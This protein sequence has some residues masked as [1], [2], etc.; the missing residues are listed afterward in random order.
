M[1]FARIYLLANIALALRPLFLPTTDQITDIPLTPTQRS[2][3]G[4]DP[5][6]S[7]ATPQ[8]GGYITPPRYRRSSGSFSG[9]NLGTP[10]SDRRSISATYYSSSP[11]SASQ[12]FSPGAALSPFRSPSRSGAS[13]FSPSASPLLHKA[14]AK[15]NNNHNNRDSLDPDRRQSFGTPGSGLARSQS[16]RERA[17]RGAE[18]PTP[19]AGAR[20]SPGM[21]YKWLYEKGSRLP[22]S[23]TMQF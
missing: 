8:S 21:N 17:A 4:L 15:K 3:L 20:R 6:S 5:S 18:S 1:W 12:N 23:E 19:S 2:L 9:S 13:Q 16:L 22:R 14:V 10:T 7:P 11:L